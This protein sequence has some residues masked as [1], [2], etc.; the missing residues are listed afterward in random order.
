MTKPHNEI[1]EL[2]QRY[3]RWMFQLILQAGFYEL[4]MYSLLQIYNQAASNFY[5]LTS[6]IICSLALALQLILIV[7]AFFSIHK[8]KKRLNNP[9]QAPIKATKL[10]KL[11][12]N[13][14]LFLITVDPEEFHCKSFFSSY[15]LPI[16][17]IYELLSAITIVLLYSVPVYQISVVVA[18]NAI[19][20]AGTIIFRPFKSGWE[21]FKSTFT[22]GVY[23]AILILIL[24]LNQQF[25]ELN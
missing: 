21:N 4:A 11:W 17:L 1:T 23:C 5:D 22:Q 13:L 8:A 12:T 3:F 19:Y 25:F 10:Q 24:E 20:L 15:F 14:S 18:I 9:L 2:N 6:M 7:L 16:S